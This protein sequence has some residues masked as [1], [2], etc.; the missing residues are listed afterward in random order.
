MYNKEALM[1][2]LTRDEGYREKMYKDSEGIWTI[3]V[4]HNLEANGL[5]PAAIRVQLNYDILVAEAS[6]DTVW[7]GW[8]GMTDNRQRVFLNMAFNMGPKRLAG[9]VK[10]LAALKADDYFTASEEMLDSTWA[11]QVGPRALRLAKMMKEG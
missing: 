5:C 7:P 2:E 3:G 4:G 6:A 10:F 11:H 1:D 8:R 9:F